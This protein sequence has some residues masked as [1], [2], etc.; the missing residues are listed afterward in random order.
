MTETPDEYEV[1]FF[2]DEDSTEPVAVIRSPTGV[3]L[4]APVEATTGPVWLE[5]WWEGHLQPIG[6]ARADRICW[7]FQSDR[8]LHVW[9]LDR[10]T[11]CAIPENRP[12]VAAA[13]TIYFE[14]WWHAPAAL[15]R[16]LWGVMRQPELGDIIVRKARRT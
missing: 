3:G 5:V 7:S 13:R 4:L 8:S 16:G 6:D 12:V 1:R 15:V 9:L 11:P 10:P 14:R 2:Q